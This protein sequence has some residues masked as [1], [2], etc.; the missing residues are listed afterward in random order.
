MLSGKPRMPRMASRFRMATVA[1]VRTLLV[2]SKYCRPSSLLST[3]LR[4]TDKKL[5]SG[6]NAVWTRHGRSNSLTSR[7]ART[8]SAVG[9]WNARKLQ[10][11]QRAQPRSNCAIS[12][13]VPTEPK[14]LC[15]SCANCS[16]TSDAPTQPASMLSCT[17]Y[18]LYGTWQ[19]DA[20]RQGQ[21][22]DH[23]ACGACARPSLANSRTLCR[24]MPK[25]SNPGGGP[26]P[27][28]L[29]WMRGLT[30]TSSRGRGCRRTER[31]L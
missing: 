31:R 5:P 4:C 10:S 2:T 8:C 6:G 11:Q 3:H 25:R 24:Y 13:P 27:F 17:R 19:R 20:Q 7:K 28:G 14:I 22:P 15:I 30:S 1:A 9:G 23:D 12:S 16:H 26:S 18:H 21:T 29:N